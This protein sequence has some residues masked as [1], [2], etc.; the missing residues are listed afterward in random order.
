MGRDPVTGSSLLTLRAAADGQKVTTCHE[1]P[2]CPFCGEVTLYF[3]DVSWFFNYKSCP[4][5]G[6]NYLTRRRSG[7]GTY[8]SKQSAVVLEEL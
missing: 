2:K 5:C 1:G 4:R 8:E 3:D 7:D 6:R